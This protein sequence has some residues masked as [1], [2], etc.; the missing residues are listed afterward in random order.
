[1]LMGLGGNSEPG[2]CENTALQA[3]NYEKNP[4]SRAERASSTY[5]S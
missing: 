4:V 2:F 5:N 3:T 1:M